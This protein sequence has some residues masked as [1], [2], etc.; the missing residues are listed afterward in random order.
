MS[1]M[2]S[3]HG[4]GPHRL[5]DEVLDLYRLMPSREMEH[6]LDHIDYIEKELANAKQRQ[7]AA[8][9]ALE[10]VNLLL[11]HEKRRS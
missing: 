10:K 9:Q 7:S 5:D 11:D 4:S 1:E 6:L 8:Q 2:K 3:A